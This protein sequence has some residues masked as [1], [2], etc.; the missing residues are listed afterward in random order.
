MGHPG[1]DVVLIHP[2]S[3]YDFRKKQTKPGPI[4][5]VIPSTPV[6]E[7][8]P[9]GFVSML[10]RLIK[11]GF[12]AR[13]VNIAV[14]MLSSNSF[15]VEKYLK[16]LESTLYG[17][18]FH[19]LPHVHGAYHITQLIKRYH[20]N[21][22]IVLGGFSATYFAD[23]IMKEWNWV[24]YVLLGDFQEKPISQLSDAIQRNREVEDIPGLVYRDES[25]IIKRNTIQNS[26]EGMKNVFLDYKTLA[27]NTIKYHDVRGHLPYYSWLDNPQGFTLIEHGCSFNCG[28][29]GGS[30]YAYNKR[31]GSF[32]P[33]YRDPDR[34][35]TEI[36][37]VAETIGSPVFIAGDLSLAGYKYY[38]SLFRSIRERGIDIPLL[39]EYFTPP[40][41]EYL[42]YLSKNFSDY[43]AE[44]SPESSNED[45]R[46]VTGKFYSNSAL[47]KSIYLANK[48]GFKRFDVYFTI[49]LPKQRRE[50]IMAD[51][52]YATEIMEHYSTKPMKVQ[53]FISP[54]S[55]FLDPGSLF[56]EFPE[57]FGYR[58]LFKD[59]QG[60]YEALDTGE[61]WEDYLNYETNN[62]TRND[63][64]EM[65]Y[66]TEI[67]L[68]DASRKAGFID[69]KLSDHLLK[70]IND[71]L[72][73]KPYAKNTTSD[74]HLAYISKQIEWS[75]KHRLTRLSFL[76]YLYHQYDR[77]VRGA[78]KRR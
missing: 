14:L 3:I 65:T 41:A 36:E 69:Q 53:A 35:A 28:F 56:F 13:I 58:I 55:P 19:W 51:V 61:S 63:I 76:I 11:D 73:G 26:E 43:T 54:L 4:S 70:N 15:D 18:D 39:T 20:P 9:I 5:D 68:I 8:Y 17:V 33:V 7:M 47:E 62:L 59:L 10:S 37:L 75:N 50:D 52:R 78:G 48:L 27:K 66:L 64:K 49:G 2:P 16:N 72:S 34:V 30:F 46:R 57:R 45:I 1:V 71:Y 6:F 29:C 40:K 22:K 21:S 25:G 77:F 67:K 32:S 24:D 23:Q 12:T 42:N 44:I 60:F 31:Y 38:T 74:S